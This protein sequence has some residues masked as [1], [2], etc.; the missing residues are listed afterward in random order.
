[1]KKVIECPYCDGNAEIRKENKEL[2]YRKETFKVV[3][4][5]YKCNK[6]LEEFT[7]TETDTIT[8]LQAHN[9]YREKHN[10]PFIEDICAIR[11]KYELPANKMSEVLGLGVNGYSNYEKGEI[12]TP[13]I[14]NLIDTIAD[15][16]VFLAL[17]HKAKDSFTPNAY[18]K[19]KE[20]VEYLVQ[21]EKEFSPFYCTINQYYDANNYTGYKKPNLEKLANVLTAFISK[22]KPEFNDKLKLNKLLFYVDFYHY[23]AVGFSLTGLSYR[24]I[25][26]GPVPTYY[27]NIYTFYENEGVICSKWIKGDNGSG[28]ELFQTNGEFDIKYHTQAELET[29]DLIISKFKNTSSWDLVDISH[30]EIGWKDLQENKGII[31]YQKYAFDL[32]GV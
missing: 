25:Q 10:I 30:E 6:C 17:L 18:E 15:P 3:A 5:Y 2:S 16:N 31:S 22:C 1:M 8:I 4:H 9:Q 23:K 19:A 24:A 14:G 13:A 27:D 26:Y 29:I 20:R 28:R 32:I 21:K 11:N 12:P 7:T